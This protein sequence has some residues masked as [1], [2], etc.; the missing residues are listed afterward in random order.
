LIAAFERDSAKIAAFR[1]KWTRS[2][3]AAGAAAAVGLGL[4]AGMLAASDTIG[5]LVGLVGLILPVA[6]W[7][8]PALGVIGLGTA[9][10]VIEQYR[11]GAPGGD[12]TD[13]IPWFTSLNDGF[14]LPGVYANPAELGIIAVLLVL[15]ARAAVVRRFAWPSG[16]V[17]AGF[18]AVL[19]AVA[20]GALRGAAAG[21]NFTMI[22]WEIRPFLYV[23]LLYF[24]ALQLS[25]AIHTL[26]AFYWCLVIGTA[27]KALQGLIALVPIL[28]SGGPRPEYLLSHDDAFF[29]GM[30]FVLVASLWLFGQKGRLR[31]VATMLL[32]FVVVVNLANS[33]R[34]AWLILGAGILITL[35]MVVV[36]LPAKRRLVA[37]LVVAGVVAFGL[38]LPLFWNATG[39][40]G[41]PARA[42]QSAIA[43]SERDR[44]SD[45]Y[46]VNE[47][48]N[49]TLAIR[50]S[51][52][53]GAGFGVPINYVLP[54]I[55]LTRSDPFLKYIAHN[56]IL[57][58]WMRMGWFGFIAWWS[59]IGFT[60]LSASQLLRSR[61]LRLAC[62]GSFAAA[63]VAGYVIEGFYDLGL[64]WFRMAFFVGL[65]IGLLQMGRRIDQRAKSER[66]A[67]EASSSVDLKK[68]VATARA[69]ATTQ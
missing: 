41:Q 32:P 53:L 13:H 11:I 50:G 25:P 48:A 8:R 2:V 64:F 65:V 16:Y 29:F 43:P 23:F 60:L 62:L 49:L 20:F 24:L 69:G 9:G 67:P 57:Y 33:R 26:E 39:I 66:A 51:T 3:I 1:G 19:L 6:I 63:C 10:L 28:S 18:V 15:V 14:K 52:P 58:V 54:I 34:T 31:T 44:L 4:L 59:L 61:D 21:G 42:V 12:L 68:T 5:A 30:D 27:I 56:G 40:L 55:D 47:N 46:R 38:Y 22:L 36:R 7:R 17:G 37:K 45:L 35:V